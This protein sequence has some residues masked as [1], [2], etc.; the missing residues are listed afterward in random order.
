MPTGKF[1]YESGENCLK[2]VSKEEFNILLSRGIIQHRGN[3][4]VNPKRE[5]EVSD[6]SYLVGVYRTRSSA[7]RTYIQ[8]E[9]ADLA[10]KLYCNSHKGGGQCG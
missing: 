3:I 2:A 1:N 10:K 7:M 4:Y 6:M 5:R 9:Y 8:D